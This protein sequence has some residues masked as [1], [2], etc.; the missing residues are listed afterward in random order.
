M[1]WQAL[2]QQSLEWIKYSCKH[3]LKTTHGWMLLFGLIILGFY[4]ITLLQFLTYI[5]IHGSSGAIINLSFLYLSGIGLWQQRRALAKISVY[6]DDRVIGYLCLLTGVITFP[7]LR[8]STSFQW[9]CSVLV[10][11]G[12]LISSFGLSIFRRNWYLISL[13]LTGLFPNLV[14]LGTLTWQYITPPDFLE[15]IMANLGSQGLR[16]M[17][18]DAIAQVQYIQMPQGAVE[19]AFGCNGFHMAFILGV[20]GF[21][22]GQFMK[23]KLRTTLALI[24]SGVSLALMLNVPR[25]MLLAIASVYWGKESFEFWHGP[26]GG[27][28]FAGVLFTVYY[29][30]AMWIIDRNTKPTHS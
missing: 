6:P 15:K 27:Q 17:N 8:S 5:T 16:V 23:S 19:V 9:I 22:I 7:L 2:G 13:L 11:V 28:I 14:Y 26:I 29:Y 12:I 20:C 1:E 4:A 3:Y 25:V 30:V 21:I 18:Y 24:A 10:I